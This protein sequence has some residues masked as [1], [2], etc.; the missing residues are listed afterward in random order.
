ML[1]SRSDRP[2]ASFVA[3]GVRR[4]LVALT[5]GLLVTACV[6]AEDASVAPPAPA[7]PQLP[8]IK[9]RRVY[10]QIS[11]PAFSWQYRS[12]PASG[13]AAEIEARR[14]IDESLDRVLEQKL[15]FI[16]TPLG[17]VAMMLQTVLEVPVLVEARALEEA[18]IAPD[19]PV[20]GSGQD[21]TARAFLRRVLRNTGLTFRLQDE[22]LL[23]TTL[24][25]DEV[26]LEVRG[27]PFPFGLSRG[28]RTDFQGLTDLIQNTVEPASWDTQGGPGA[29]RPLDASGEPMLVVS[30]AGGVHEKVE[31]L[32][33][34]LHA[35]G[36]AEFGGEGDEARRVTRVHHVEDEELRAA[37]AE[38]LAELANAALT[39]GQDK[40]AT[41]QAV[42]ESIVVR[43]KSPGLHLR[44]AQLIDAM[45]GVEVPESG[46]VPAAGAFG[47]GGF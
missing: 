26:N 29:I 46:M 24:E 32:L 45:Q 5:T 23:I 21:I 18:G 34:T 20:T 33:A 43:S 28:P 36:L 35:R 27:Y 13:S 22:V 8:E 9:Y 12:L 44:A 1:V 30:H 25:E 40:E 15:E 37:L 16:E 19:T 10:P 7:A 42:G 47:G 14:R 2:R 3:A 6:A 11:G 39:E 4:L 41:A 17:D 31:A 38:T